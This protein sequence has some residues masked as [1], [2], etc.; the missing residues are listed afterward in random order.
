MK[1]TILK[2]FKNAKEIK[3]LT[4]GWIYDISKVTIKD[5]V[6]ID[7]IYYM[8]AGVKQ[9]R[10]AVW[11]EGKY[12]EIVT[13]KEPKEMKEEPKYTVA[14]FDKH[15]DLIREYDK[16]PSIEIQYKKVEAWADITTFPTF[17]V[18]VDFRKKPTVIFT[19]DLGEEFTLEEEIYDIKVYWYNLLAD[20]MENDPIS[21]IR[22]DY[23]GYEYTTQISKT[24]QGALQLAITAMNKLNK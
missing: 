19:N 13:T 7:E 6:L 9:P 1:E 12:A 24:K 18:R 21:L 8:N 14:Q 16:D 2:H 4:K 3:C 5:I 23:Q 11:K 20:E 10:V 17:D 15:G 22:P